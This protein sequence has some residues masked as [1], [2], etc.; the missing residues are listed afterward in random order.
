MSQQSAVI[1]DSL[2]K[3]FGRRRKIVAVDNVTLRVEAGQ[4][5]GFL[6]PN[7]AGKT[8]T[9]RMML[10]LMQPTSGSISLFGKPI[11]AHHEVLRRVGAHVEGAAFYPYLSGRRNLEVIGQING[12]HDS[13]RID[14]LLRQVGLDHR[15]RQKFRGYSLGMKQ[16]LGLAAALMNDPALLIMD[17]PTNGLDPA[18][19][20]EM[21]HFLRELVTKHGKTVFLSSHLLNEVEQMCDRVAIIN[22]GVILREGEVKALLQEKPR[23][24]LEAQP[25]EQAAALLR[26]HWPLEIVNDHLLVEATR[27]DIPALLRTLHD[28]QIDIYE[29][30]QQKQSLEEFFLNVTEGASPDGN[31]TTAPQEQG[32]LNHVP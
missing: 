13:E 4:V 5:Y 29:V 6:G 21:R 22:R 10:S 28:N 27:G 15:A 8:T 1:L 25:I 7:G 23:I 3:V 20:Q 17:E 32:M 9:I 31:L 24:R 18:G 11:H 30:V 12:Y 19:I 14:A 16:R 26:P 2:T